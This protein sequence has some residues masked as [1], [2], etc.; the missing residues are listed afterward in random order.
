[1]QDCAAE[2]NLNEDLVQSRRWLQL[3]VTVLQEEQAAPPAA[4]MDDYSSARTA[5]RPRPAPAHHQ[6][7][8]AVDPAAGSALQYLYY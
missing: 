5:P 2:I 3:K 1:M 8:A 4:V 7:A 6:P